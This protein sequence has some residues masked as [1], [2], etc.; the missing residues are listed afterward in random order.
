MLQTLAMARETAAAYPSGAELL[1][2]FQ[3]DTEWLRYR[4]AMSKLVSPVDRTQSERKHFRTVHGLV[5]LDRAPGTG[6]SATRQPFPVV[7]LPSSASVRSL[8]AHC[9]L[10]C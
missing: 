9:A 6:P 3:G 8:L 4:R 5:S 1:S 10:C 7:S 2:S